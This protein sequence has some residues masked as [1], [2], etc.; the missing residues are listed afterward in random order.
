[1]GILKVI[2][3]TNDG[4]AYMYN[5]LNYVCYGHTDY[6]RRYSIN[7]DIDNAYEQFL[8]MKRYFYKTSGNPVFHFIVTYNAR[9]TWGDNIERAEYISHSIASYFSDRFQVVWCIHKK[10]CSK[11][12]GGCASVYHAHFVINSVSYE[13]G[14]MFGGS[15]SEIYAFLEHIKRVTGDKSWVVKYGSDKENQYEINKDTI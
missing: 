9:T 1:M 3:N 11:E 6:N 2:R 13:D 4:L 7:T 12:Y 15:N 10:F 14:K 8:T 5:A